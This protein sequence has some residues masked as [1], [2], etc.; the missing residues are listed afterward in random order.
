[1]QPEILGFER[2]ES[3]DPAKD[4]TTLCWGGNRKAVARDLRSLLLG[5]PYAVL[6]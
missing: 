6:Y 1:M 2:V 5:R 4:T 3:K